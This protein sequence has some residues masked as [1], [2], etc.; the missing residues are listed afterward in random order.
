MGNPVSS[1]PPCRRHVHDVIARVSAEGRGYDLS[2]HGIADKPE[3]IE[4][5]VRHL[6]D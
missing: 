4:M 1:T 6:N 5:V 2:D 3:M